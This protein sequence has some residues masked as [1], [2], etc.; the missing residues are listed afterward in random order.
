[1]ASFARRGL[2]AWARLIIGRVRRGYYSVRRRQPRRV[3]DP[4]G[5]PSAAHL[6]AA[7]SA[8]QWQHHKWGTERITIALA[9]SFAFSF[10]EDARSAHRKTVL[11]GTPGEKLA[12]SDCRQT[13][14]G[15]SATIP[16]CL[17]EFDLNSDFT[18]G[19]LSIG[20]PFLRRKRPSSGHRFWLSRDWHQKA[21]P[22]GPL[23]SGA[24]GKDFPLRSQRT[25]IL[26]PHYLQSCPFCDSCNKYHQIQSVLKT[27][28]AGASER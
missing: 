19:R 22:A 27:G 11:F 6:S 5:V 13:R 9:S 16:S 17:T 20:P 15:T 12:V 2:P 7:N 8:P 28:F 23:C 25:P 3:S 21:A 24:K 1:M 26:V 4:R 14:F 10:R 18:I